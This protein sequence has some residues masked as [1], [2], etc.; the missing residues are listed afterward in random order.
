VFDLL[1]ILQLKEA[2]REG[3]TKKIDDGILEVRNYIFLL[4]NLLWWVET[5]LMIFSICRIRRFTMQSRA[6]VKLNEKELKLHLG[7]FILF[8]LACLPIIY[9][10][11]FEGVYVGKLYFTLQIVE[12]IIVATGTITMLVIFLHISEQALQ[13]KMQD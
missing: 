11:L 3:N 10:Q 8:D 2:I 6:P 5:A 13:L 1:Y 7:S 12:I 4:T 9:L